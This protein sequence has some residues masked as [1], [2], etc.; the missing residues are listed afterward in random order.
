MIAGGIRSTWV[1]IDRVN[2]SAFP[3]HSARDSEWAMAEAVL[4]A[5]TQCSRETELIR[6][7]MSVNGSNGSQVEVWKVFEK[8]QG[9]EQQFQS[10]VKLATPWNLLAKEISMETAIGTPTITG[11]SVK[12]RELSEHLEKC[13]E[14]KRARLMSPPG[15]KMDGFGSQRACMVDSR[16]W[17]EN[18]HVG[19]FSEQDRASRT[20]QRFT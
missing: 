17:V 19:P 4:N 16:C 10:S 3:T 5:A 1:Q 20:T 12:L 11:G 6:E 14:D 13:R 18:R 2:P 7:S 8:V 15:Q 9:G